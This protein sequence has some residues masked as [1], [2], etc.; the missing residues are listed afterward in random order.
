MPGISDEASANY[1]GSSYSTVKGATDSLLRLLFA[2]SALWFRIRM[3]ITHDLH[4]R[5]FLTKITRYE[6]VCSMPNSM[7]VLDGPHGLLS[8][9]LPNLDKVLEKVRAALSAQNS[10]N[11]TI[12]DDGAALLKRFEKAARLDLQPAMEKWLAYKEKNAK[13]FWFMLQVFALLVLH[14]QVQLISRGIISIL[15]ICIFF[16]W[17]APSEQ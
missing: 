3:P 11:K 12:R 17:I 10:T 16:Q 7:S 14:M 4:A 2:D 1:F 8:L 13:Y 5:S 15:F 6:K 9:F